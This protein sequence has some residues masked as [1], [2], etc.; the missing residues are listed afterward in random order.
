MTPVCP[1]RASGRCARGRPPCRWC[2]EIAHRLPAHRSWRW[3]SP[4]S[5]A[6]TDRPGGASRRRLRAQQL[7]PGGEGPRRRFGRAAAFSCPLRAR[8]RRRSVRMIF[9]TPP[10][11]PGSASE[12]NRRR[13]PRAPATGVAVRRP[14]TRKL[15]TPVPHCPTPAPHAPHTRHNG[16][17]GPV[18]AERVCDQH[19]C[20]SQTL[21]VLWRRQDSN[22][23]RLSRQIYSLLPLAA[24]AHRRVSLPVEPPFGGAP[25]QRRKQY[26]MWRGA[27]PPD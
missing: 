26:L 24:R 5:R 21:S 10:C 23:G 17:V 4:S 6:S 13:Q 3:L 18:N 1:Q 27:S 14:A 12:R 25:W 2:G 20:C 8:R 16:Q 7:R 11:P 9:A 22:L 19:C 15:S